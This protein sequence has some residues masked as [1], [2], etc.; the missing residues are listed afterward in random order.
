MKR[1]IWTDIVLVLLAYYYLTKELLSFE[2]NLGNSN[3][4]IGVRGNCDWIIPLKIF[5]SSSDKKDFLI[6]LNITIV[7]YTYL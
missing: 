3:N 7:Y 6:T 2:Q 1:I 5:G 4:I